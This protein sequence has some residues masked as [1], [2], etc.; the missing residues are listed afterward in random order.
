MINLI[1][2]RAYGEHDGAEKISSDI[3]GENR[4]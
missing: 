3:L 4:T 1:G 2:A